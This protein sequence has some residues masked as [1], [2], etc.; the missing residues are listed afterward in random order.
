MVIVQF[1]SIWVATTA[2]ILAGYWTY[3]EVIG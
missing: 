2:G 1:V 3:L